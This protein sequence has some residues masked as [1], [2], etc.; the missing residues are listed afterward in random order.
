MPGKSIRCNPTVR[1]WALPALAATVASVAQVGCGISGAGTWG[2]IPEPEV[3]AT[4]SQALT[5]YTT[6][7]F[8]DFLGTSLNPS[9]WQ[10]QILWVNGELQCYDNSYNEG[11]AHKT[12]EVSNGSLKL[13]VVNSGT[14]SPCTNMDKYGNQHGPTQFKGGRIASKNRQEFAQGRWTANLLLYSWTYQGTYGQASGLPGMFPAWWVLGSRNNEAPVQEPDENVCWPMTG[15]GEIDIMEHQYSGGPNVFGAR[16][17]VATGGCDQG[18][19]LP[20]NLVLS[21]DLSSYHQY[22]MENNGTDLI[23]RIDNVEVGRNSGIGG[24][25]PETFF[26]ILNYALQTANMDGNSKE[27]VMQVDWVKHESP[28]N[29]RD[30]SAKLEAESNDFLYHQ[31]TGGPYETCSGSCDVQDLGWISTNDSVAWLVNVPSTTTY[32]LTTNSAVN[33]SSSSIAVYTG[34]TLPTSGQSCSAH[35]MTQLANLTLTPTTQGWQAWQNYT[36]SAFNLTAG[37][38]ALCVQFTGGNQ[39]LDWVSLNPVAAPRSISAHLQAEGNDAL[40]HQT[41][42]GGPYENCG[43]TSGTC[44][45]QDLGWISANDSVAW[46]VTVPSTGA[47]TLTTN[48]AVNSTSGSSLAVYTGTSLP[49]AGQNCSGHGMTLQN[50]MSLA[51]TAGWQAWQNNTSASFNLTAGAQALCVQFTAG[52]QNLDWVNL[53]LAASP[54][55]A[56]TTPPSVPTGL[57]K[58]SV[59]SSSITLGWTASTDPDSPVS[60]YNVYRGGTKVGSST[61]TS[62]TDTG[63]TSNTSYSYTV[64]AFD[65]SGNTSAQSTALAITTAAS[66]G[67]SFSVPNVSNG[68]ACTCSGNCYD[69]SWDGCFTIQ[70]TGSSTMTN[71]TVTFNVPTSVTSISGTGASNV[72]SGWTATASLNTSTSTITMAYT[73]TLAAG[74]SA[75]VYYTTNNQ[76]E[77]AATNVGVTCH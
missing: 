60:G 24:N 45:V 40:Y 23:F 14:V 3:R 41:T 67:C 29:L 54:P 72:P 77:A 58:S 55:P 64:S 65:P 15:S 34:S 61:T 42:T 50:T 75:L 68:P 12:V 62:F 66:T 20:Y 37:G 18:T 48:D 47:Y 43:A 51:N 16:G 49:S 52:N 8:D 74:A 63:L 71:P 39:N 9:N 25:Y 17:I 33:A 13:R 11:G 53:A 44:E 7:F 4:E 6:D 46:L 56:D 28:T 32:A 1:R 70:N 27:Y 36:S 59:T 26:A 21:S 10:D 69:N 22:Q 38:Q 5:T 57:A 76:T 35:G 2:E 30:I 19:Y 73:G 31:S